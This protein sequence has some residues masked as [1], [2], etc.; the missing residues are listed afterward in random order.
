MNIIFTK[1]VPIADYYYPKPASEFIP[2]WYKNINSYMNEEK[3]PVNGKTTATIK[4]C[5]PV[6]DSLISGYII[7]TYVDVYVE[8]KDGAPYYQWAAAEP[9]QWHPVEQAPNHPAQNGA[10]YPKWV[11]PWAIKTPKGYSALFMPPVHRD[12]VFSIL[13]GI[14]DTDNYNAPVNF[15]FVL[16]DVKYEGLIPA[17]TPMAQVIPFKREAWKMEIG[18]ESNLIEQTKTTNLLKTRFFDSYKTFFRQPKEYK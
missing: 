2:D 8:Q 14:V 5:M 17:G 4:K 12:S 15:P 18:E 1:T 3:K 10:P 16:N 11:N 9:I 6:F 13:E 7:T